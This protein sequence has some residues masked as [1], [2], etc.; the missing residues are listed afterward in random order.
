MPFIPR[1]I[2]IE[3]RQ[4]E[5]PPIRRRRAILTALVPMPEATMNED[6]GFVFGEN[7]V[8]ANETRLYI[9]GNRHSDMEPKA[10][11]HPVQNGADSFLWR[12]VFAAN[13]RHIPRTP[14]FCEPIFVHSENLSQREMEAWRKIFLPHSRR[15]TGKR[16]GPRIDN[17]SAVATIRSLAKVT[18]PQS[19]D[20]ANEHDRCPMQ[21]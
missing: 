19:S 6:G 1:R 17:F 13:T 20:G 9:F 14:F 4:P 16:S 12:R 18:P 5:L 3:F 11:A 7:D 8:R 2:A 10:I 15:Q 21:T